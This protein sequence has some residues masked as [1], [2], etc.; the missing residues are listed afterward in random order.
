MSLPAVVG[1][2]GVG[3][4]MEPSLSDE[5]VGTLVRSADELTSIYANA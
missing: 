4:V 3:R 2:T 5:Q 1:W